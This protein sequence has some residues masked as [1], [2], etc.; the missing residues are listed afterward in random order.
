MTT[1]SRF[2]AV[3]PWYPN[4]ANPYA[5]IF[6]R[7]WVRSYGA[8]ASGTTIIHLD[9]VRPGD[10]TAVSRVASADGTVVRVPVVVPDRTPR[11]WSA[12]LYREAAAAVTE[13]IAAAS[14]VH[15]HVPIPAGFAVLPAVSP[16]ARL[17]VIEHASYAHEAIREPHTREQYRAVAERADMLLAVSEREARVIRGAIPRIRSNVIASGNP[18]DVSA[19]PLR[20]ALPDSLDRWL[21]VGALRA[22]KGA[23]RVLEAFAAFVDP[24]RA[25][26]HVT[27]VGDGP[28][29][30]AL[31]ARAVALGVAKRVTF[32]S[33]VEPAAVPALYAAA[34]LLV[35][36][37]SRETFGLTVVEAAL[38]GLPVVV[39]ACG[40]PEETLAGVVAAGRARIVP[41]GASADAVAGAAGHLE[42]DLAGTD[43]VAGRRSL[44]ALLGSEGFG[45][46]LR[47]AS[48]DGAPARWWPESAAGA[49]AVAVLS[50]SARARGIADAVTRD[51][52]AAGMT[53]RLVT[54]DTRDSRL[55]DPRVE[56]IDLG[57]RAL[58]SPVRAVEGLAL[59]AIPAALFAL[60]L[61]PLWLA[62]RLPGLPGKGSAWAARAIVRQRAG[63]EARHGRYH[64]FMERAV[65]QWASG[66][67]L[68][69]AAMR[70]I[71][72]AWPSAPSL[73]V[74]C[75]PRSISLARALALKH[76]D[77]Q[78]VRGAEGVAAVRALV[79][80]AVAPRV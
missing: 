78:V 33:A 11:A 67:P 28:E 30:D 62:S 26:A 19:Y 29:R 69:K 14:V 71:A 9:R 36:L 68:G 4:G 37:S 46:R 43:A 66:A 41:L 63:V 10:S 59:R 74:Y 18:V 3:T 39:T 54:D 56:V 35:H 20:K 25:K 22:A 17:V 24:G 51:A 7:E 58:L 72:R 52:L 38:S 57:R 13:E 31:Q 44:E 45:E 1:E 48:I 73:V 5:G 76:P 60:A 2:V 21:Y 75:E 12:R 70:R 8:P 55:Q 47:A 16:G 77:A 53:V 65:Y 49:P 42:V 6:V 32:V 50:L 34:D 15:A 80:K 61:G 23:P 40:G 64:E 27:F 79:A